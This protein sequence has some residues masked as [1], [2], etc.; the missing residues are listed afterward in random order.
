M[1]DGRNG[2]TNCKGVCE[3]KNLLKFISFLV[4]LIGIF[5]VVDFRIL[6]LLG[7]LNFVLC[8][9]LKISNRDFIKTLKFVLPLVCF[10]AILNC[11]LANIEIGMLMAIRLLLAYQVTYVFS[12]QMTALEFA[13]VIQDLMYP[14]K[15]FKINPEEIG[16]IIR[17][18]LCVL[19]ILK[20]EIEQK[21]EA[22][23]AKGFES[24]LSNL[25]IIVKPLFISILRRTSEM[26]KTLKTRGYE[27]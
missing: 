2:K 8:K 5:F 22:L 25:F 13:K 23:K 17:I 9:I 16:I 10:T 12:K 21:K 20:N 4:Y 11:I 18:A 7:L 3:M 27:E 26:E 14:L 15:I 24:K 6:V 19:P 1:N